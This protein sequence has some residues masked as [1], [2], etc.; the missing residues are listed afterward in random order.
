MFDTCGC[1]GLHIRLHRL[2]LT[3]ACSQVPLLLRNYLLWQAKVPVYTCQIPLWRQKATIKK[4]PFHRSFTPIE[5]VFSIV[6]F[7]PSRSVQAADCQLDVVKH[8]FVTQVSRT[9]LCV[10]C[11]CCPVFQHRG[12]I[13]FIFHRNRLITNGET[14]KVRL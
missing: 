3:A 1:V 5:D 6:S 7:T 12:G 13:A 10:V 11:V 4:Y 14:V 9:F 2:T 8:T